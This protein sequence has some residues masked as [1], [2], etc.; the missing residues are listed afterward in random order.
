M[1]Q[2]KTFKIFFEKCA[3]EDQ[4]I[5]AIELNMQEMI[6]LLKRNTTLMV[7]F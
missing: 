1:Q 5:T 7:A 6:S 4:K 3:L 2:T